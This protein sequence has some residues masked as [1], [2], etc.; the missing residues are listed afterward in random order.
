MSLYRNAP[1]P[2]PMDDADLSCPVCS[3]PLLTARSKCPKCGYQA[4]NQQQAHYAAQGNSGT[5]H[6]QRAGRSDMPVDASGASSDYLQPQPLSS[7]RGVPSAMANEP[8]IAGL[9]FMGWLGI[10]F[11]LFSPFVAGFG[12]QTFWQS[13]MLVQ[14]SLILLALREIMIRQRLS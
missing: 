3:T 1:N 13:A 9:F 6:S 10:C 2:D 8:L 14:A 4:S 11:A 5:M 7:G 12:M